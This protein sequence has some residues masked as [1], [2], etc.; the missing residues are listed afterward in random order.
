MSF[1]LPS[2]LGICKDSII[3]VYLSN[4]NPLPV[5]GK[6]LFLPESNGGA[7]IDSGNSSIMS[8]TCTDNYFNNLRFIQVE[9][10]IS[11]YYI[12]VTSTF[13]NF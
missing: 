4:N 9:S 2:N 11:K 13:I 1:S 5:I 3:G 7:C 8:I 12:L 10:D 6:R